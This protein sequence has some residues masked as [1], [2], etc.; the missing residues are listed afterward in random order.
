MGFED[1]PDAIKQIEEEISETE[2]EIEDL[3]DE[4]RHLTSRLRDLED[5]LALRTRATPR[6]LKE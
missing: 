2:A 5:Q 6:A 4:V 3:E 1:E